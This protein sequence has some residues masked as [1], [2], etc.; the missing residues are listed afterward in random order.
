MT[1]AAFFMAYET[2]ALE[3]FLSHLWPEIRINASV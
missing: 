2:Q 3:R 1:L